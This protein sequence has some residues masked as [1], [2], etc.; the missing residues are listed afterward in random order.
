[1]A[2]GHASIGTVID[3]EGEGQIFKGEIVEMPL[4]RPGTPLG[5][6]A[7]QRVMAPFM[8]AEMEIAESLP[9]LL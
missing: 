1:L 4:V 3:F 7:G 8:A 2:T 5:Q 6:D 9:T